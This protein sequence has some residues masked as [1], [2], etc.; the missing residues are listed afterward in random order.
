MEGQ[1]GPREPSEA[2]QILNVERPRYETPGLCGS[3]ALSRGGGDSA[4][5][6]PAGSTE[7]GKT[8]AGR[9]PA[10]ALAWG[11]IS[12]AQSPSLG[13]LH[14]LR[15]YVLH[16]EKPQRVKISDSDQGWGVS[17]SNHLQPCTDTFAS[18]NIP[19]FPCLLHAVLELPA[20][21]SQPVPRVPQTGNGVEGAPLGGCQH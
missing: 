21:C 17:V 10:A 4:P 7:P 16:K 12:L 3:A 6:L 13:S 5:L 14:L 20:L 2:P 19:P 9:T 1:N 8:G 11:H 15:A 18:R